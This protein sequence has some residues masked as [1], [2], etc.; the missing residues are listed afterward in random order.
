MNIAFIPVRCGSKSIPFKNI[1]FFCV[2]PLVYWSL[3]AIEESTSIQKAVVAT[4][5]SEIKDVVLGFGF[6]KV[7]VFD[8][9]SK[10]A[11]DN[12]STES[13]LLEYFGVTS[14]INEDYLFLV[15]ATSP[16][17]HFSDFDNALSQLIVSRKDSLLTCARVKRFFWN[18]NS[19]PI[20]YD[21]INRPRRQDFIGQLVEN[22]A[23]YINKIGNIVSNGNRL[24]GEISIYEMPE[25]TYIE[26]DEK[27]DWPLA[28]AL[29]RK[30]IILV[31]KTVDIKLFLSDV[32]GTLTD[33]GMYYDNQGG[34]LK[35]FNTHDGMGFEIL[36]NMGLKTGIVTSEDTE[37]VSRRAKKLNVDYLYQ[38]VGGLSKLHIVKEICQ[39]EE[40]SLN[41]VAYIGDDVNCK[42]LLQSVGVSACPSNAVTEIKSIPSIVHM[43]KSGGNGAVREFIEYIIKLI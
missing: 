38:G 7:E 35:K 28:E 29:M 34:E 11:S 39:Q 12:S 30:Y 43:K 16:W 10:N 6:S 27:D 41:Q 42:E 21:Y 17:T 40:I 33:A 14:Y 19:R 13:V 23:F 4:D 3:K 2:K 22:G 36:R 25:Y 9:S 5:C 15:Q 8:R 24:S 32:D 31:K 18:N 20:N 37:I 1:K 26:L